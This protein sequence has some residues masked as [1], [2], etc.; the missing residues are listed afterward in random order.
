MNKELLTEALGYFESKEEATRWFKT[1]NLA[2]G[3][4]TP[5]DC[6]K[7]PGGTEQVLDIINK[8]KHGMTA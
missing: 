2:L 3:L 5:E 4:I 8:L 7:R 6:L 1:P